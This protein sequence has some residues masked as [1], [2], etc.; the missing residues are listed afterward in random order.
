MQYGWMPVSIRSPSLVYC[1]HCEQLAQ[2]NNDSSARSYLT[3]KTGNNKT[4]RRYRHDTER[5]CPARS[6]SVGA[7]LLESDFLYLLQS[8]TI[9]PDALPLVTQALEYFNHHHRPQEAVTAIQ[10][11]I[12]HWRQR[13]KNADAMF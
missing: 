2:V 9:N 1:A 4:A 13:A 3:A 8:L 11:E 7:D 10:A 6:R 5:R 12:A